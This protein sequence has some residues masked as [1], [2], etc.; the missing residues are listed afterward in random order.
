[1]F[2]YLYRKKGHQMKQK[3]Y[4]CRLIK[5]YIFFYSTYIITANHR[6]FKVKKITKFVHI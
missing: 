3:G 5:T 4:K 2:A 1:M 6:N